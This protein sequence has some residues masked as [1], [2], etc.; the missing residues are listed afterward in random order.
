MR[1]EIVFMGVLMVV[2]EW[3]AVCH[4]YVSLFELKRAVEQLEYN[5]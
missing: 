5:V 4:L 1:W 3:L 2:A